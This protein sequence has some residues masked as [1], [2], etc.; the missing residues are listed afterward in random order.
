MRLAW[1]AWLVRH[2]TEFGYSHGPLR[3][4]I[5]SLSV[6][7]TALLI[8]YALRRHRPVALAAAGVICAA[9]IGWLAVH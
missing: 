1:A 3:G 2:A 8:A 9:G 4:A 7:L 5:G 6:L